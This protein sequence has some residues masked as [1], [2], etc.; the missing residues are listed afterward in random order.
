MTNLNLMVGDYV[1]YI[2]KPVKCNIKT[3]YAISLIVGDSFMYQPIPLSPE[4]MEKIEGIIK[5]VF[6]DGYIINDVTINFEDEED[7]YWVCIKKSILK[8]QYLHQLQQLIRLFTGK[9]IEVK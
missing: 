3:I 7:G 2:G 1:N 4:V 9:E 5:R 8:I 6:N